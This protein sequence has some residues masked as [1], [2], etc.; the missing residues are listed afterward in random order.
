MVGGVG[1]CGYPK[2]QELWKDEIIPVWSRRLLLGVRGSLV[3][4]V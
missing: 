4:G 2:G 3:M 1:V